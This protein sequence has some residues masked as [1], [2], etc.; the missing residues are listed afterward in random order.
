[1][2]I[3]CLRFTCE[4]CRR[5]SSIQIFYNKIGVVK[6]ARARHYTGQSNGKPQSEYHQQSIQWV[7]SQVGKDSII[8]QLTTINGQSSMLNGQHTSQEAGNNLKS[9]LVN[10]NTSKIKGG[11]RL[12]WFRTLAFQANDPGFKSRRPHQDTLLISELALF[13]EFIGE[14]PI[15]NC[16]KWFSNVLLKL[17]PNPFDFSTNSLSKYSTTFPF[18]PIANASKGRRGK[19]DSYIFG[20]DPSR[21]VIGSAELNRKLN[22]F[23]DKY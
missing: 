13:S 14:K 8:D 16:F 18:V 5:V 11:R 20:H 19:E 22:K 23:C 9:S 3:K 12:V 2:K 6:Y 1:M 7:E 15:I 17:K 21:F 10:G 4:I